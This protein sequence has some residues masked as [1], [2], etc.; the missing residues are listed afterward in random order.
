[1]KFRINV[2]RWKQERKGVFLSFLSLNYSNCVFISLLF[3]FSRI[4]YLYFHCLIL[5]T[6]QQNFDNYR[7]PEVDSVVRYYA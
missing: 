7:E 1:M 6:P 2:Y 5:A 3:F 4:I